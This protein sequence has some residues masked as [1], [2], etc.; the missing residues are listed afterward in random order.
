MRIEAELF[1]DDL[2]PRRLV[3]LA[4]MARAGAHDARAGRVDADFGAVEHLDAH[5]VEVLARTRADDFGKRRDADAHQLAALALL[6]LFLAQ[7][8][9]ADQLEHALERRVIVAAVVDES[10]RRRIRE[11]LFLHEVLQ[12]QLRGIHPELGRQQIHAALDGVRRFGDAERTAIGDAARRL[13]RKVGVEL[14][15]RGGHAGDFAALLVEIVDGT[16]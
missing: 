9:V 16:E 10:E 1:G 14:G 7:V 13:V 12:P 5:D 6:G 4:L 2:R 3:A 8:V 11:L 15:E